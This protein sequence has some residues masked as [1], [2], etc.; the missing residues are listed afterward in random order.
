M[1]A[2]VRDFSYAF[3]HPAPWM[4]WEMLSEAWIRQLFSAAK[5]VYTF[6]YDLGF[7]LWRS[8]VE[9]INILDMVI[10]KTLQQDGV[11]T[12]LSFLI[13]LHCPLQS[14]ES[15]LEVFAAVKPLRNLI[16]VYFEPEKLRRNTWTGYQI[17]KGPWLASVCFRFGDLEG[18][19]S[20]TLSLSQNGWR[21]FI[22]LQCWR[23]TVSPCF[24]PKKSTRKPASSSLKQAEDSTVLLPA[25]F[26]ALQN[27]YA[28]RQEDS[29]PCLWKRPL[30][31]LVWKVEG[32]SRHK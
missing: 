12:L 20:W 11:F 1:G 30:E 22:S 8:D 29:D 25:L 9:T 23:A 24:I 27:V 26:S 3:V 16:N 2:A 4:D 10:H 19:I 32:P 7:S 15:Q 21:K 31:G 17:L 18:R 13:F 28:K 6:C 14:L 5:K